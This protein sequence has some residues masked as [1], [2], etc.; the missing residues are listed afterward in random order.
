M[1]Q[2]E[3]VQHAVAYAFASAIYPF[4][5][6]VGYKAA[7]RA[8]LMLAVDRELRGV[9][10][11]SRS[12]SDASTLARSFGA[13]I[14]DLDLSDAGSI[15]TSPLGSKNPTGIVELPINISDDRLLGGLDLDQTIASGKP[16]ISAGVLSKAN[17]RVLYVNNID[18]L[19]TST[20][21]HLA[22]A[23][24]RRYVQI[25]REGVSARHKADFTLVGTF[26]QDEGEVPALLCDRIGLIVDAETE[27][28]ND[29]LIEFIDRAL[30]FDKNPTAFV[31]AFAHETSLL[32]REIESSHARLPRVLITTDQVRKLAEV[33]VR[34]GVEGNRADVF[35]A[36]TARASAA[37]ASRDSVTDEDLISAIQLVLVPRATSV[38]KTEQERELLDDTSADK[39]GEQDSE[40]TN[41][42]GGDSAS[43]STDDLILGAFDARVPDE[44]LT[45]EQRATRLSRSGKATQGIE[46]NPWKICA[47]SHSPW[48][49]Q[50]GCNRRDT[51]SCGSVSE[52]TSATEQLIERRARCQSWRNQSR[53]TSKDPKR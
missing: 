25:E 20:C 38:P 33:A 18:L 4:T 49:F 17:A 36:R 27:S 9:L 29:H 11:G 26:D 41:D 34:L 5:A 31:E 28:K 8:L 53:F 10:I 47:Q 48:L 43:G 45:S 23:L 1:T 44:L 40:T 50:P 42:S 19:E 46:S 21:G 51:P 12:G 35:A 15:S 7:K 52:G 39:S 14:S 3:R 2:A 13:L 24:D 22:D 6:I 37:L 32:K 30:R 16:K